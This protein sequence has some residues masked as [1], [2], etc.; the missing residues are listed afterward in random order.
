LQ[1]F[2]PEEKRDSQQPPGSFFRSLNPYAYVII[3]L[4]IIFFLYQFIGASIALAAG[5][6][7]ID[8]MNVKTTRVVLAF[9]QFML[10]LAPTLFFSRLQTGEMKKFFRLNMPKPGLMLLAVMGIVLIQPFIQGYMFLQESLINSIPFLRD[11]LKPFKEI[12]DVM[13]S[14]SLKLVKAHSIPEFITIIFVICLTPAIC[15]EALFRGFTLTNLG[16]VAKASAAIFMSGF[17]FAFYHF[18]PFNIVPLVALGCYLGFIVY[19]SNSIWVGVVCHF[20]NNFFATYFL[21]VYGKDEFETPNLAGDEL[22]N[23]IVAAI[24]SLLLFTGTVIMYYRMRVKD[25]PV[26]EFEGGTEVE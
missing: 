1:D 26:I 2:N 18:Q 8:N 6:V 10:I 20:L 23:T 25:Q 13:E 24:V 22:T 11:G 15:E 4:A 7:D 21:Y 14:S 9:G 12:F 19:Y 16:R 3:V 17:L 5:G